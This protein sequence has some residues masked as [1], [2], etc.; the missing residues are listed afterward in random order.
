VLLTNGV[1]LLKNRGYD[2][3]GIV[4]FAKNNNVIDRMLGKFA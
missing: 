4:S 1:E 2:S 3:A